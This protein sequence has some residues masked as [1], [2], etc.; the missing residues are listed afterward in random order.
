MTF[1]F[2][3]DFTGKDVNE[4]D[5]KE[6]IKD[7]VDSILDETFTTPEKR[8]SIQRGERLN[9]ACPY[10]GDSYGDSY[11]KRANI[12]YNG[13]TF[14]CY[15]CGKHTSALVFF[16]DFKKDIDSS[17]KI[18]LH[19]VSSEA[20]ARKAVSLQK[21]YTYYIDFDNM[22][23]YALD[24]DIFLKKYR[25][26]DAKYNTHIREYLNGRCQYKMENFAYDVKKDQ[27]YILNLTNIGKVV[28]YQVRNFKFGPKYVT[29]EL[30]DIYKHIGIEISDDEKEKFE[31]ANRLS[32]CFG[33]STTNFNR[34]IIVTEGP[35]DSFLV[36]N[37][38]C[39]CGLKKT[40]PFDLA[41]IK[42]MY[43]YDVA[44]SKKTLEVAKTGKKVFMWR[45]YCEAAGIEKVGDKLDWSDAV[46]MQEGRE[47]GVLSP[48]KF[49]TE[50][51]YDL[52]YI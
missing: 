30:S 42:Y 43:D 24:R 26:V 3:K 46:K 40:F 31:E 2:E 50:N 4:D 7:I 45:K 11:K 44:G 20:S 37:G 17:E 1:N 12:Y 22:N 48:D 39:V 29:H 6:K 9:F 19:N 15:N 49:F 51:K 35:L 34:D 18:F 28:G 25:L 47:G 32:C 52:Y 13:Y 21:A 14:H 41:N 38:M 10:C 23:R 36:D 27:L 16:K 33:I 8:V 5:L